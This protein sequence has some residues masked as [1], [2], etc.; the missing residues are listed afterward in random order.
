MNTI[1][2]NVTLPEEV[3]KILKGKKSKSSYIAEA[4]REKAEHEKKQKLIEELK[5]GYQATISEDQ[6]I[7][8]EWE[9]TLEDEID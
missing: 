5:E 2:L 9:S 3:A 8:K 7:D 4:L 1:R 6:E